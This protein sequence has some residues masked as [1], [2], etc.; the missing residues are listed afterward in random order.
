MQFFPP[1]KIHYPRGAATT[2]DGLGFGQTH[3]CPAAGSQWLCQA[4]GSFQQLLTEATPAAPPLSNLAMQAQCNTSDCWF[5]HYGENIPLER[6]GQTERLPGVSFGNACVLLMASVTF[7]QR[8]EEDDTLISLA[9]KLLRHHSEIFNIWV[10]KC[11]CLGELIFL[12]SAVGSLS[13]FLIH[14]LLLGSFFCFSTWS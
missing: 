11:L 8:G 12:F 5:C 7:N 13:F 6:D 10:N 9:E 2:A 1:F 14:L 4:L 3:I